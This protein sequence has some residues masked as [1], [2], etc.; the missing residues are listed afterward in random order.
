[1][2][3]NDYQKQAID[4]A[5][6][7]ISHNLSYLALGLNG[8]AGEYAEKIK[9]NIRDDE[10]DREAAIKELGDVLWYTALS[11]NAIGFDLS[12]VAQM[13]IDKLT[14]RKKNNTLGGNGDDR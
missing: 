2:D 7:H 8:E 12:A 10:F 13:N 9:K 5:K 1:M 3:L 14:N 6:A 4:F 11:A